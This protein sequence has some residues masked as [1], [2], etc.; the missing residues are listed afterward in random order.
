MS[1]KYEMTNEFLLFHVIAHLAYHFMSGEC[2]IRPI[3]DLWILE[4]ELIIV[5]D[6]LNI[7]LSDAELLKFYENVRFLSSV[8]IDGE[9][10]TDVAKQMEEYTFAGG[11]YRSLQN[12]VL[13]QQQRGKGEFAY[14][15]H[16]IFLPY[17][18]LKHLYPVIIRYRWLTLGV[19]IHRWFKIIFCGRAKYVM[20]ELS[21]NN[22]ISPRQAE[23]MKEFLAQVGL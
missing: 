19:Q 11:A 23:N 21:Y 10:Y 20:C 1:Y 3:I 13:L 22:S 8:W 2:G 17:S 12:K 16:R 7:F 15:I 18:E 5:R 6:T 9:P 4:K 14:V